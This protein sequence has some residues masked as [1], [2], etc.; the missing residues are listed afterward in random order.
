MQ[1][2]KKN[3]LIFRAQFHYFQ[4]AGAC[5]TVPVRDYYNF[6]HFPTPIEIVVDGKR[7]TT[8]PNACIFSKPMAP[9]G[10]Y[11]MRDTTM[12]WIHAYTTIEPLL[13]KYNIPL[14]TVFYPKNTG[15][16]SDIF[17]K[18]K[19]EIL[20]KETHY[21]DILDGYAMQ[22]LVQLS[23]SI[24]SEQL[25]E[26]SSADQSMLYRIRMQVLS[27]AGKKWTVEE[28]AEM[29]SLSPSRF[30]AVYKALF[31]SSPMQDVIQAK[32]DLAKTILL[33]ESK[34][35]LAEVAERL[36]YKNAQHFIVQFKA[37]TGMTPGA[38]R[39]NN[40]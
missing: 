34:P 29:A 11:F 33:L 20:T 5:I 8:K 22:F 27:N 18:M 1:K 39:R 30:H 12:N 38:Y 28:M 14:N 35:S 17:R 25:P 2:G 26:I 16:I 40:R 32:M 10:F 19:I 24:H 3:M 9:R 13:E 31:G 7:F 21:G 4:K 15:F 36:G 6:F 37:A 23:R